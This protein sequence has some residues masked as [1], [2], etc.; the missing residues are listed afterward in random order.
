MNNGKPHTFRSSVLFVVPTFHTNLFGATKALADNGYDV[1]VF[2]SKGPPREHHKVDHLVLGDD[3]SYENI[4]SEFKRARP[5]L[6]L[7]RKTEP[8]SNQIERL[9]LKHR[10]TAYEYSLRPVTKPYKFFRERFWKFLNG[11]PLRRVSPVLGLDPAAAKDP[12][13]TFLPWPIYAA[14]PADRTPDLPIRFLCV[15]KLRQRRKNQDKLIRALKSLPDG[16]GWSLTLAGTTLWKNP[17]APHY[18]EELKAMAE[19]PGRGRQIKIVQ[20]LPF[21]AMPELYRTHDVCVMP[22]VGEPL[23]M[24]TAEAMAFGR[25]V[26]V[27]IQSGAA[28]YVTD[29]YDGL[30]VDML[31]ASNLYDA[32]YQLASNPELVQRLG[33]NAAVTANKLFSPAS[34]IERFKQL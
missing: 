22:S 28:G 20:D 17:D 11:Q 29:G 15:G 5:N 8:L 4:L 12:N 13:A 32:I 19:S 24:A 14:P 33:Q 31:Q 26:A 27:S 16:V 23:G 1:T 10:V 2:S 21:H 25:A 34:F 7:I 6:V 18:F 3:S 30:R 9:A